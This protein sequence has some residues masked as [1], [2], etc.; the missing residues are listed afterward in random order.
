MLNPKT[1]AIVDLGYLG[2]KKHHKRTS[3]P[4]K[5]SK[6]HPLTARQKRYNRALSRKRVVVE[7]VIRN[8]K[9]FN[10]VKNT[11]RGKHKNYGIIW[12]IVAEL[13]NLKG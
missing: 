6:K 12:N 3:I 7:N 11:Y 1:K 2:I 4:Y 10:I 8:C 9:I 5:S 13:V